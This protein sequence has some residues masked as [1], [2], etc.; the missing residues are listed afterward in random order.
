M[1]KTQWQAP[2]RP[3]WL[4]KLNDEGNLLD[5][6]NVVP[7]DESSLLNAACSATGLNNFGDEH[8]REPFQILIR[9]LEDDAEL[10][11]MG[12]LM[13]RND[14]LIWLKNRL[15][16]TELIKKHPEILQE[17]IEAPMFI[18]GLPRSGTSILFELLWQDPDVGVPLL[19][20]AMIPCPPPEAAS[21]NSDPRIN[22]VHGI[23]TQW[24]RVVPEY[25]TMHKMGGRLPAECGLIMANTFLSDHCASLQQATSY[26]MYYAQS[27]LTHVYEY[28]KLILQILQWK[29]PRKRWLL[30]APEHQ[31]NLQTLLKIY[32]DARIVQTHRDPIKSMAS[33]TSLLGALYWMRSDKDFDASAFEDIIMGEA[34][35]KRLEA[36][37]DQRQ[38]GAVPEANIADSRYQDLMDDPISC[39]HGI[40]SHFNIKLSEQAAENMQ[41]YLAQKPKGKHGKHDYS[42]DT[43]DRALFARYQEYYNVPSEV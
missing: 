21:Y 15:Q 33:A 10:N 22:Y 19:W 42:V 23:V 11:M 32:P 35:A 3:D 25:A 29:N 43:S 6:I 36:V 16:I 27:D 40:Y 41:N 26:G 18:V 31:N 2:K 39:I 34:T 14:I 1:S 9:S 5:L 13:A 17:K 28:H 12:R 24:E 30:K 38:S 7:L 4:Q 8:W 37:I 20:E